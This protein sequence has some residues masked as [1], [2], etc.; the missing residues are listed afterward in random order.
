MLR[1]RHQVITDTVTASEMMLYAASLVSPIYSWYRIWNT[2]CQSMGNK[3]SET[4]H[5]KL[6]ARLFKRTVA[7]R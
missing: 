2:L 7:Q 1:Y 5:Q 4:T 6:S 3:I